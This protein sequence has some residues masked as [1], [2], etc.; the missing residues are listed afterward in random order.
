[1]EGR[2]WGG[3]DRRGGG[4]S[5]GEGLVHEMKKQSPSH[6]NRVSRACVFVAA[7]VAEEEVPTPPPSASPGVDDERA[8]SGDAAGPH[9]AAAAPPSVQPQKPRPPPALPWMRVPVPIGGGAIPLADVRGL[10][11]RV[12]EWLRG[13]ETRERPSL[14]TRSLPSARLSFLSLSLSQPA[15]PRSSPSRPPP[16]PRRPVAVEART[17]WPCARRRGRA[18]PWRT[19]CPWSTRSWPRWLGCPE[20]TG[21]RLVKGLVNSLVKPVPH[22]PPAARHAWAPW[23][24]FPPGTW[25]PRCTAWWRGCARRH[26]RA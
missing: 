9:A 12:E 13:G 7:M 15:S 11:G 19:R 4:G 10:D 17:T 20:E 1:M 24:S 22:P 25:P 18:R 3:G 6:L 26:G 2:W 8:V 14:C 16:G 23:S 21:G 5:C